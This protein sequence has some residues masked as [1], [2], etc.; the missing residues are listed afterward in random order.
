MILAHFFLALAQN[1]K[2]RPRHN[3]TLAVL[4]GAIFKAVS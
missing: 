4:V 2:L 1:G 3:A